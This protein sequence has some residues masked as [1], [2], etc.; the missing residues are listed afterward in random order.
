MKKEAREHASLNDNSFG[1]ASVILGIF[2]ILSPA[3]L[4]GFISGITALI[5]SFKQKKISKNNWSR[6]GL[7]LS[8]IG[9]ILNILA[10]ILLI[11]NPEILNQLISQYNAPY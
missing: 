10:Y 7:A 3:P 1:V 2:T 9:I 11:R 4:Y 5:F 6:W 8:I